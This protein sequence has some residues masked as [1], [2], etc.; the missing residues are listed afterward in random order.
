M[1]DP[2]TLWLFVD[3]SS[4]LFSL[5]WPLMMILKGR[6]LVKPLPTRYGFLIAPEFVPW[7]Q[8]VHQ[9]ER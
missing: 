6:E 4:P 5:Y 8:A 2:L 7:E 1:I 9:Y 3:Q